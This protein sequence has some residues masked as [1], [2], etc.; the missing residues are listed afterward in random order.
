M[1]GNAGFADR[2]LRALAG[3]WLWR[4]NYGRSRIHFLYHVF[5]NMHRRADLRRRLDIEE[6]VEGVW[7]ATS[8]DR[9]K[10]RA[11]FTVE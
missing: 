4:P 2:W 6:A 3:S 1:R 10:V 9:A 8:P 7:R 11:G 5:G